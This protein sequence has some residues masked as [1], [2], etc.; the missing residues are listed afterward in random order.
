[1]SQTRRAGG[2]DEQAGDD[3]PDRADGVGDHLEVGAL[4]VEALRGAAAQQH[5]GDEVDDQPEHADDDHGVDA[6]SGSS[7]IAADRRDDD[8]DGDRRA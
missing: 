4:D 1:M 7:P 5:E 8:V 6:T 2:G 3:D